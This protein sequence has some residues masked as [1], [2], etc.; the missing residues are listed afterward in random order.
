MQNAGAKVSI[1][2]TF[3]R[4]AKAGVQIMR[5]LDGEACI[6]QARETCKRLSQ[7]V[8]ITYGAYQD[9]ASPRSQKWDTRATLYNQRLLQGQVS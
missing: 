5:H 7:C 2:H 6:E 1:S 4:L 8:Q 3:G 9:C